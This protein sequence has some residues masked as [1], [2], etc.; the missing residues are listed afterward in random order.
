MGAPGWLSQLRVQTLDLRSGHDLTVHGI[1]PCD[2]L[3]ADSTELAW[4]SLSLPLS[5]PLYL[6][7]LQINKYT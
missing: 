4:E 6:G 7:S 1:E 3:S 5:L 2:G